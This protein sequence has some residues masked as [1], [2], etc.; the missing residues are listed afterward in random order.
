MTE[1]QVKEW[2][3]KAENITITGS[4]VGMKVGEFSMARNVSLSHEPGTIERQVRDLYL[5]LQAQNR[6]YEGQLNEARSLR[7]K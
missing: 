4:S 3:P 2:C 5:D 6:E 1:E 7:G